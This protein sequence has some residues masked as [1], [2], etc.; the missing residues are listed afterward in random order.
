MKRV[1]FSTPVTFYVKDN[2]EVKA[3]RDGKC[4]IREGIEERRRL[5]SLQYLDL[6]LELRKKQL[7]THINCL[8]S[9]LNLMSTEDNE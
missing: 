1:L 6:A 9:A 3:T 2:N 7:I 4:W 5:D 8:Y